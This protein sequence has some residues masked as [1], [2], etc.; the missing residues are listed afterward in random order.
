M[1]RVNAV[2]VVSTQPRYIAEAKRFFSL[3]QRAE[4]ATARAWHVYYVKN[5]QSADLEQML[6]RAFTPGN[7]NAAPI[8]PG[9]TAPGAE[10]TRMT[11]TPGGGPGSGTKTAF[12]QNSALTGALDGGMPGAGKAPPRAPGT[13]ANPGTDPLSALSA[14]GIGRAETEDGI[15]II[16]NRRNNALLI[17]ATPNEYAVI[18]GMLH[19]IDIIPL[20]VLIESTI[21]EVTLNDEL[22]Y[23]TQFYLGNKVAGI[24]TTAG[25][26]PAGTVTANNTI[27]PSVM[28]VG[29]IPTTL[30]NNFPGFVLANGIREVINAL[31]AVTRIRVLSAPQV[32]VLDNEP[33]RL[34]VGSLVPVQIQSQQSTLTPNAPIVNSIDYRDTGIIMLVYLREAIEKRGGL[35]NIKSLEELRQAV[36][37]GAVHRLRPK[38]LTEGVAIIA[39]FPMVFAKGVGGEILAPMA[40]PVLG[41]L[42][43]SDEVVDLF[44]PVRFYWVCRARWL[45]LHKK[46]QTDEE[47][48]R[49]ASIPAF[50]PRVAL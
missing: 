38:L 12:G 50:A 11:G 24:L 10:P 37:E 9:S 44:L 42:L 19:K 36:I 32:M 23:G 1:P 22:A 5:G 43:I 6:Q 16:A 29:G 13:S 3:E 4:K 21:A 15:R 46:D 41:G 18:E 2:L 25:P 17:Y 27:N 34:Q 35:E 39:I 14:V 8:E 48:A 47:D 30:G 26:V 49:S 33:A 31:S 40:L 45:K 28:T 7:V 20:Q